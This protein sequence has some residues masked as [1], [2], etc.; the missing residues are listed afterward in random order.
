MAQVFQIIATDE[1]HKHFEREQVEN[2][3]WHV[4]LYVMN[5]TLCGIQLDGDDGISAG[6]SIQGIV[7]CPICHSIIQEV[8]SIRNWKNN[9]LA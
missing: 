7:T 2:G 3:Y 9:D 8:K 4:R 6:Q 5:T 1:S